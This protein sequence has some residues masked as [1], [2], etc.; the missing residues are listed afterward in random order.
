MAA[1]A[2]APEVA[3]SAKDGA[4]EACTVWIGGI[5][6]GNATPECLS[7]FFNSYGQVDLAAAGPCRAAVAAAA[8]GGWGEGAHP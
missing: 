4:F 7:D 1:A 6:Q 5:P 2:A 8:E 3:L